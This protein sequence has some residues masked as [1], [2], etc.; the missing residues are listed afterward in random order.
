MEYPVTI[1]RGSPFRGKWCFNFPAVRPSLTPHVRGRL[2]LGLPAKYAQYMVSHP[3]QTPPPPPPPHIGVSFC[4]PPFW[5]AEAKKKPPIEASVQSFP[6]RPEC[7]CCL[8]WGEPGEAVMQNLEAKNLAMVL[9]L[10]MGATQTGLRNHE[11]TI[12]EFSQVLR[13]NSGE[14]RSKKVETKALACFGRCFFRGPSKKRRKR[15]KELESSNSISSRARTRGRGARW[16][17][18]YSLVKS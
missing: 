9:E 7:R 4:G 1:I 18:S 10:G 12:G 17:L 16:M 3:E 14:S 8:L 6:L 2:F 5:F 11:H 13:E 15:L